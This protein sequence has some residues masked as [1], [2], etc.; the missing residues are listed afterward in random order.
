MTRRCAIEMSL[1]CDAESGRKHFRRKSQHGAIREFRR[2]RCAALANRR[3]NRGST[4]QAMS[5]STRRIIAQPSCYVHSTRRPRHEPARE[6]RNRR[7]GRHLARGMAG[8]HRSR[9]RLSALRA[10]RLG[11][12]DLQSLL[13]AGA[14]RAEQ[15]PDEAARA[16]VDRGHRLEPPQGRHERRPRR[17]GGRQPAGLHP[18]RRRAQGPRPTS[19]ARST[20]TPRPAWRSPA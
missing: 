3:Q 2:Q 8:P 7:P 14:G 15:V 9:R 16:A 5:P 17:E 12:P 4:S 6:D 10:L 13:D 20:S 1:R 19:I 18:A 11:R